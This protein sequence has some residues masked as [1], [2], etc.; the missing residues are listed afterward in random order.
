MKTKA[1]LIFSHRYDMRSIDLGGV[2]YTLIAANLTN[3]VALDF[4]WKDQKIYWSDVTQQD[5]RISVMNMDGTE[6][7]VCK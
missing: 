5:S 2:D 3:A 4:D 1:K 6:K 7:K